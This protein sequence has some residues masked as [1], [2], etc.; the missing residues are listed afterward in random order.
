MN[1]VSVDLDA[2]SPYIEPET[3]LYRARRRMTYRFAMDFISRHVKREDRF[4]LLEIGTGSGYFLK[5]VKSE[6]P[7]ANLH[8]IEYDP[9]LLETTRTRAPFADCVQ[10]NAEAFDYAGRTFDVIVSFQVIEHLF[11]PEALLANVRRHLRPGGIFIVTTP[12]LHGLGARTM[13]RAWQGFRDDHV[14]LKGFD[15]WKAFI[16]AQGFKPEYCG[17]TF[18]SGIPVLNRLPLGLFNWTLLALFGSLRWKHGE[19]FVGV[20][21]TDPAHPG[22][23]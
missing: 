14:S 9:R 21:Q 22:A 18:F 7:H 1:K 20:F 11:A 4:D 8:G 19:A 12:N 5:F 6:F 13:G 17:S 10:G 2:P 3:A 23:T 16:T 15:Q